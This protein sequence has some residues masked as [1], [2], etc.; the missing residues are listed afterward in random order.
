LFRLQEVV[1]FVFDN[2]PR[3][4]F[5]MRKPMSQN[6][7]EILG[8]HSAMLHFAR[9]HTSAP[10]LGFLFKFKPPTPAQ[11]IVTQLRSLHRANKDDLQAVQQIESVDHCIARRL[12][13]D[14]LHAT[15]VIELR[16]NPPN[17]KAAASFEAQARGLAT[18]VKHARDTENASSLGL[19]LAI[20][21]QTES[22]L[23]DS[24]AQF[25]RQEAFSRI[26]RVFKSL[27][28]QQLICNFQAIAF[29]QAAL[30]AKHACSGANKQPTLIDCLN[31]QGFVELF[32]QASGK[33]LDIDVLLGFARFLLSQNDNYNGFSA[34]DFLKQLGSLDDPTDI[35]RKL[36]WMQ[37]R[38]N[39]PVPK[40]GKVFDAFRFPSGLSPETVADWLSSGNP[41][42]LE[43]RVTNLLRPCQK[44]AIPYLSP[45]AQT[46]AHFA[47]KT[48]KSFADTQEN[49]PNSEDYVRRWNMFLRSIA[50]IELTRE[51]IR[52]RFISIVSNVKQ[53]KQ[54]LR[55]S[56][57]PN[58]IAKIAGGSSDRETWVLT[59]LLEAVGQ[60]TPEEYSMCS[61][62]LGSGYL[63]DA[64][65][66]YCNRKT[67]RDFAAFV[68]SDIRN[69]RAFIDPQL[70]SSLGEK[71][72]GHV[73][74]LMSYIRDFLVDPQNAHYTNFEV[75][76]TKPFT[77]Q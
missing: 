24:E 54:L 27:E 35:V 41:S 47:A 57:R 56:Q 22:S 39:E 75:Y 7:T 26:H 65:G 46:L 16:L 25:V 23:R 40:L 19:A 3:Y 60:L 61:I 29:C 18:L 32:L 55:Q 59:K 77:K 4:P 42:E 6:G 48:L 33:E 44:T 69:L 70:A 15:E 8:R 71:N 68:D 21:F 52:S 5:S 20:W 58:L 17:E 34:V 63:F 37:R 49:Q 45:H 64:E 76:R 1:E 31:D 73:K 36:S 30:L 66:R 43:V 72:V 50:G 53:F 10:L 13:M 11:D 2:H 9:I 51:G 38:S 14:K 74:R 28:S 67:F 12:A 62:C